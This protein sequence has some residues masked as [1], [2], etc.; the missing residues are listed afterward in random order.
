MRI[1]TIFSFKMFSFPQKNSDFYGRAAALRAPSGY[2]RFASLIPAPPL[3][4]WYAASPRRYYP[5]RF[6]AQK[7][8]EKFE[9]LG[10]VVYVCVL[11][12]YSVTLLLPAIMLYF[13]EK[14]VFNK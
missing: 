1:K 11:C 14:T 10:G 2:S 6:V 4:A 12:K 13:L 5:S 8:V 7:K 3:A 9:S